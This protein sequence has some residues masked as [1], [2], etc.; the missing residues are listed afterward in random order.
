MP[1]NRS[2]RDRMTFERQSLI[3]VLTGPDTVRQLAR[4]LLVFRIT[5]ANL[6]ARYRATQRYNVSSAYSAAI[7]SDLFCSK[8]PLGLTKIIH[9]NLHLRFRKYRELLHIQ[10]RTLSKELRRLVFEL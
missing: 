9:D 7:R 3:A 10:S 6:A 4:S 8:V 5:A 2:D 1:V